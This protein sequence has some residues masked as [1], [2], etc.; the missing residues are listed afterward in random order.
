MTKQKHILT[1]ISL[2]IHLVFFAQCIEREKITYGGEYGFVDFIHLCPTYNFSYDG[3]T[4]KNWNVLT[5][6]IDI[7]Q[8]PKEVLIFKTQIEKNIRDY[9]GDDLYSKLH[10]NSVEVVYEDKLKTF[11]KSGRQNVTL[12]YCKAKYFYYYELKID[13]ISTYLIGVAL[14]KKG[15][16]ISEFRFPD[17]QNYNPIDTNYD[18][19]KLIEIAKK[20]QPQIEPIGDIKLYY[21]EKTKK[22][23]WQITQEIVNSKEGINYFNQVIIDAS[24]LTKTKNIIGSVNIVY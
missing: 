8:A 22:F 16:I 5:N 3:D 13:A 21:D 7:N 18:Y 9:S 2:F 12:K 10:F 14:D 1:T 11:K 24:D 4:S 6:P 19:C 23:Y 20:S 17:K 15:K